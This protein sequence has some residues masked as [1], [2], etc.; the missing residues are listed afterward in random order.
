MKKKKFEIEKSD[1]IITDNTVNQDDLSE[2]DISEIRETLENQTGT[3]GSTQNSKRFVTGIR[4]N[5]PPKKSWW[6][7]DEN[8]ISHGEILV[9]KNWDGQNKKLICRVCSPGKDPNTYF[10]KF[11]EA[12]NESIIRV[13]EYVKAPE[14]TEYMPY[15]DEYTKWKYLQNLKNKKT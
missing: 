11:N 8:R 2:D 13:R 4:P 6:D 10:V 1:E 3:E 15:M 14:G 12:M 9:P 5:P 7:E